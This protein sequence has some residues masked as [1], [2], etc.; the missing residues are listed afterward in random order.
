MRGDSTAAAGRGG[1]A[2][3]FEMPAAAPTTAL[4]LMKSRLVYFMA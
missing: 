4:L 2:A 1:K 3:N